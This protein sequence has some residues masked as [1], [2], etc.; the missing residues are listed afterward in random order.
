VT[1]DAVHFREARKARLGQT[2]GWRFGTGG[3]FCVTVPATSPTGPAAPLSRRPA[4]PPAASN[5]GG[6]K[7]MD[8]S[9]L[10]RP[11]IPVLEK[12]VRP[13]IVYAFILIAFRFAGKR[14]LAAITPFDL[15]VLLII[16]NLVQNAMIGPDDSLSG[17]LIGGATLIAIN[18]L[19]VWG[20]LRFPSLERVL[21]GTPT[22]LV[23]RG[24]ILERNMRHEKMTHADLELAL[25]K[26]ELDPK[27]DL[28]QID[29]A[30]LEVDGSV[31]VVRRK[32]EEPD[33]PAPH[34]KSGVPSS[35]N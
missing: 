28:Q 15:V 25:R 10:L 9:S 13:I 22:E 2:T 16:S 29:K 3:A 5:P 31:T 1:D 21:V 19:L 32:A 12:I 17:G 26:H 33:A 18:R 20:S 24:R 14:E 30:L 27:R 8:W 11:E 35:S 4:R 6:S 23:D 34:H 7:P